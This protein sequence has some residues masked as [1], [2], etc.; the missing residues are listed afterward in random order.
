M[1]EK[2]TSLAWMPLW[3]S[4]FQALS[5]NLTPAQLGAL[6]RMRAA[7][8]VEDRPCTLPDS[9]ARLASISGLGESWSAN[10]DV[11]RE[12]FVPTE[13]DSHGKPRLIDHELEQLYAKQLARYLAASTNGRLGGRPPKGEGNQPTKLGESLASFSRKNPLSSE[14]STST[15]NTEEQKAGEKLSFPTREKAEASLSARES[16]W[17]A[18]ADGIKWRSDNPDARQLPIEVYLGDRRGADRRQA[19]S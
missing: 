3:I 19:V 2:Q 15:H 17:L 7:A 11:L 6:M 8:W 10:S 14:L 18:T 9:D 4:D 5:A 1:S 12:Y 16:A 13:P